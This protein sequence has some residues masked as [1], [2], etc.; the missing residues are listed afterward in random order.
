[1]PTGPFQGPEGSTRIFTRHFSHSVGNSAIETAWEG[2]AS[3]FK[4][5]AQARPS[6]GA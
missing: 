3:A 6:P 4:P 5:Q 1:M 2:L